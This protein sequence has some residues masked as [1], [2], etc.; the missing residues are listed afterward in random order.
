[1]RSAE[2]QSARAVESH[3]NSPRTLKKSNQT[4]F[5][6]CALRSKVR[7]NLLG[8]VSCGQ[9]VLGAFFFSHFYESGTN[10]TKLKRNFV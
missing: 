5:E 1:M 7:K 3:S 2:R 10:Y 6:F 4:K 8:F 9:F